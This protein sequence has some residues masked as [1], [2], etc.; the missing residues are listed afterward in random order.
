MGAALVLVESGLPSLIFNVP[1][2]FAL[3][4]SAPRVRAEAAGWAH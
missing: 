1:K 2:R 4:R 3:P